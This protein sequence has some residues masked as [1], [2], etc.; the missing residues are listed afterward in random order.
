MSS[1]APPLPPPGVTPTLYNTILRRK[2]EEKKAFHNFLCT[3]NRSESPS[4]ALTEL[5]GVLQHIFSFSQGNYT[6]S[7][8]SVNYKITMKMCPG[9]E[10]VFC[11]ALLNKGGWQNDNMAPG[12]KFEEDEFCGCL[13]SKCIGMMLNPDDIRD[14]AQLRNEDGS[15]YTE[16][17]LRRAWREAREDSI[18]CQGMAPC[19]GTMFG[20]VDLPPGYPSFVC[21]FCD[22]TSPVREV[23]GERRHGFHNFYCDQ[24]C[25]A[26]PGDTVYWKFLQPYRIVTR[27][28]TATDEELKERGWINPK[29]PGFLFSHCER[30]REAVANGEESDF[31]DD[32]EDY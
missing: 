15:Y 8:K 2:E 16:G 31:D 21:E 25:M 6:P 28:E 12:Q 13:S 1:S 3:T 10:H 14:L 17:Q 19:I 11:E 23:P 7:P 27:W 20:E 22:G 26:L 9:T 32:E 24:R 4:S 5:T 30:Y 18:D 29:N